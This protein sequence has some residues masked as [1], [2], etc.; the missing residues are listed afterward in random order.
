MTIAIV[1]TRTIA[2]V[3]IIINVLINNNN[4]SGNDGT[5][6]NTTIYFH[7]FYLYN[8]ALTTTKAENIQSFSY[9]AIVE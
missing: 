5:F 8:K 9:V 4:K 2:I 7:G 3:I 1:L 6:V